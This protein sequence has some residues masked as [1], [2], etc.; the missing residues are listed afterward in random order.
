[1]SDTGSGSDDQDNDYNHNANYN[2]EI[3]K[4]EHE[5]ILIDWADNALCYAYLYNKEFKRYKTLN[6]WFTIPIIIISTLTGTAAFAQSRIP[7]D[8]VHIYV[9]IV[10]TFNIFVGVISTIK[11]FLKISELNEA[12]RVA[13]IS[14]DKY[15]RNIKIEMTK[16]PTE[17]VAS[18]AMLKISKNE[19]DRLKDIS[20]II[21]NKSIKFFKKKFKNNNITKPEICDKLVSTKNFLYT[22]DINEINNIELEK[23]IKNKIELKKK[24]RHK[25]NNLKKIFYFIIEF[26]KI[27]GREPFDDEIINN[28]QHKIKNIKELLKE[29]NKLVN[30]NQIENEMENK[31]EDDVQNELQIQI[32]DF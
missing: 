26:K 22:Q 10:G 2:F 7:E 24:K 13:N 12:H 11:N 21:S 31:I 1:M 18:G 8:Y 9:I 20:P 23:I 5:K 6:L 4:P 17:R 32:N 19:F 30:E 25:K 15:Y 14:W 3:W 29:R 16:S 28:L 27:R